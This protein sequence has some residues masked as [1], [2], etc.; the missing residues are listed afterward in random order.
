MRW[1]ERPLLYKAS[2]ARKTE[3]LQTP[4]SFSIS[5]PPLHF[6]EMEKGQAVLPSHCPMPYPKRTHANRSHLFQKMHSAIYK[7]HHIS[8]SLLY[9]HSAVRDRS[10]NSGGPIHLNHPIAIV[11]PLSG[12]EDWVVVDCINTGWRHPFNHPTASPHPF[13]DPSTPGAGV[14]TAGAATRFSHQTTWPH[15]VL[16]LRTPLP[17]PLHC[18]RRSRWSQS[19]CRRPSPLRILVCRL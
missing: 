19:R 16:D 15:H 5:A 6:R 13:P 4:L 9:Y 14:S 1:A 18:R 17:R 7:I 11:T 12:F 10:V 2:K 8:T 3:F